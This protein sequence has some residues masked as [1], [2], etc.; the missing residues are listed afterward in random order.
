MIHVFNCC[1]EVCT[2][3][4]K[5]CA[6]CGDCCKGCDEACRQACEPCAEGCQQCSDSCNNFLNR[7]LGGYVIMAVWLCGAELAFLGYALYQ[8]TDDKALAGCKLDGWGKQVG[9]LGWIYGQMGLAVVSLLFAPYLQCRL[10]NQLTTRA[11]EAA[12][13]TA[14]TVPG[15][16]GSQA[17][18]KEDVKESFK[19]V[20]LYDVG[21]CLYFFL[22][23]FSYYWSYMGSS[24]A[25]SDSKCNP[26]LLNSRAAAFGMFF[27]W[28][29]FLYAIGWWC[30]M[31][32]MSTT[33]GLTLRVGSA[34]PYQEPQAAAAGRQEPPAAQT[35]ETGGA[36]PWYGGRS[37]AASPPAHSPPAE[38]PPPPNRTLSGR[39]WIK[40]VACLGLD[41]MG[42][43][44][45]F[46]PALGEVGDVG[47][48]PAQAVA[49]KMMFDANGIAALGLVEELLPFTDVL[50]TATLAW[51]LETCLPDHP[52]TRA[53]GLNSAYSITPSHR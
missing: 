12:P 3:P 45:Y 38:R 36:G 31:G 28:F 11:E 5:A 33:E 2:L 49:L 53:L 14:P 29:V 40:L 37:Q 30:Y 19:H 9:I 24:W 7:P 13:D 8:E 41:F 17:V 23:I 44:S 4:A 26:Q 35:M 52:V 16:T 43:A 39:Q 25:H 18:T 46:L 10:W 48:A 27:V 42:N 21:F 6:A 34:I 20:F 47:F 15:Y 50:P 51:F 32:C 22:L 1:K